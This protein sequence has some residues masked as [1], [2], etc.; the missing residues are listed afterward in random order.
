MTLLC[1]HRIFL[2]CNTWLASF[3]PYIHSAILRYIL[4]TVSIHIYIYY[5]GTCHCNSFFN[6]NTHSHT[7]RVLGFTHFT[8]NPT[9]HSTFQVKRWG[10]GVQCFH[11]IG[12]HWIM[13]LGN[14]WRY[15]SFMSCM[16]IYNI[17]GSVYSTI[18]FP[19]AVV[20]IL[21]SLFMA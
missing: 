15:P 18:L 17:V 14:I 8:K 13:L 4:I 6:D 9:S 3:T 11:W 16:H 12:L 5:T 1:L 7:E 20:D 19:K 2:E 10:L 21:V